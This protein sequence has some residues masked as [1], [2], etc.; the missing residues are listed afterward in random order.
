[1]ARTVLWIA[2]IALAD[3]GAQADGPEA[4]AEEGVERVDFSE[5]DG[6]RSMFYPADGPVF[7]FEDAAPEVIGRCE[8]VRASP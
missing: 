7:V 3:G 8:R 6:P 1:V 2:L 5:W 4:E